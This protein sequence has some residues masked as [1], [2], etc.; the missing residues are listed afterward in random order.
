MVPI[1]NTYTKKL[2]QL[3]KE[4]ITTALGSSEDNTFWLQ[5]PFLEDMSRLVRKHGGFMFVICE[6]PATALPVYKLHHMNRRGC[7]SGTALWN[8]VRVVVV[9]VVVFAVV[10]VVVV[11]D[12]SGDL[13]AFALTKASSTLDA[14]REAKQIRTQILL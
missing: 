10:V 11:E 2:V 14:T 7:S 12:P 9:V 8:H 13:A 5:F 4:K 1:F 3:Y 6:P